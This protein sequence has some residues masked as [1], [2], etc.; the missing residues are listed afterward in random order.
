M[1]SRFGFTQIFVTVFLAA[2]TA[3]QCSSEKS[4]TPSPRPD[5]PN[6]TGTWWLYEVSRSPVPTEYDSV[7]VYVTDDTRP[8]VDGAPALRWQFTYM[9]AGSLLTVNIIDVSP[10]SQIPSAGARETTLVYSFLPYARPF[11][12]WITPLTAGD[13][14]KCTKCWDT[15]TTWSVSSPVT[16]DVPAGE[17][18]HAYPVSSRRVWNDGYQVDTTWFVHGIGK[19]ASRRFLSTHYG[20][21]PDLTEYTEVER[22]VRYYVA[23]P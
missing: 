9:P 20:G 16:V 8:G 10:P 17:F 4:T 5:F 2:V 23:P 22:L 11:E 3:V 15:V 19:V 7:R 13:T 21:G 6:T 18:R 14:W 12:M 1:H